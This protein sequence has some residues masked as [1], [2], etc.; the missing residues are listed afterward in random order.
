MALTSEQQKMATDAGVQ[1][2][3]VE[4][5]MSKYPGLNPDAAVGSLVGRKKA[6]AAPT[7][8]LTTSPSD[9]YLQR[10]FGENGAPKNPSDASFGRLNGDPL[11]NVGA[12]SSDPYRQMIAD[13]GAAI[14]GGLSGGSASIAA[15][16]SYADKILSDRAA[17]IDQQR[18]DTQ[19]NINRSYEQGKIQLQNKQ[20]QETGSSSAGL[21]RIGGYLGES[22]SGM[23]Y[24]KKLDETHQQELNTLESQRQAALLAAD[25]AFSSQQ[26][27]VAMQQVANAKDAEQK[28]FERKNALIDNL[29]KLQQIKKFER[30]NAS[31]T[32]DAL[33]KAGIPASALPQGYLES[34]DS[35]M[36]YP[37][38]VSSAMFDAGQVAKQQANAKNLM[39]LRTS[40]I[41]QAGKII[42][43]Q[44]KL[45]LGTPVN[46]GG[47][48]YYG[49]DTGDQTT[50][51]EVDDSGMA[52]G[53]VYNKLSD[54]WSISDLGYIGSKK[55][56]FELK[57]DKYGRPWNYNPKTGQFLSA[58]A[59][60]VPYQGTTSA[61][62]WGQLIPTGTVWGAAWGRKNAGQCGAFVNDLTG[63]GMGDSFASK[64]A[65]IDKSIS[66]AAGNVQVGDVAVFKGGTT[67][68][69]AIVEQV[70]QDGPDGQTT[71]RLM[72]ANV[73]GDGK[74]TH[75]RQ[76]TASD[77]SLAGF[78]RGQLDPR[79]TSGPDAPP[80]V[81]IFAGAE[82]DKGT[83]KDVTANGVTTTYL[84]K[85][86]IATPVRI[87]GG[88]STLNSVATTE[89]R[90]L[91]NQILRKNAQGGYDA[92]YTLPADQTA[93]KELREVGGVPYL[94]DKKTG[95]LEQAPITGPDGTVKFLNSG[96]VTDP[97]DPKVK[98]LAA[99]YAAASTETARKS[100]TDQA[101]DL[102]VDPSA[103]VNAAAG[104]QAPAGQI[105]STV[106]HAPADVDEPFRRAI[107]TQSTIAGD[108]LPRI[109]ETLLSP[110][111][112]VR[113]GTFYSVKIK[114]LPKE[115]RTQME[116]KITSLAASLQTEYFFL[117]SGAQVTPQ[118]EERLN[119]AIPSIDATVA[120]NLD[121]IKS[122][123][124]TMYDV[125]AR[126]LRSRGLT[127]SGE[128]I[129]VR[130]K[131]SG[132]V[133]KIPVSEFKSSTYEVLQ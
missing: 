118:E 11:T 37:T 85:N 125:V 120:E 66:L 49:L 72:E 19:E 3:D 27:D 81:P 4:A 93:T 79:L 71:I 10:Y 26:F 58:A 111:D 132:Q 2:A 105:V 7:L 113:T 77:P 74:V 43:I 62:D 78:A 89:D 54:S 83:L 128:E 104:I 116:D 109:R 45:P 119:K 32:V 67:G 48:T 17:A 82:E 9:P 114:F 53:V 39:E 52:R 86:G 51:V 35:A 100:I 64:A 16:G 44:K 91:G 130:E 63:V 34:L 14:T 22:A 124:T 12:Y 36:G 101:K 65:K 69:V 40:V 110:G 68:H 76:V 133:G 60:G 96:G 29:F 131:S 47:L 8:S 75:G 70:L 6:P 1:P 98:D 61:S 115:F 102:G 18:K 107:S 42:D 126:D 87:G 56:G 5:E 57:I 21:A 90:V 20:E 88:T 30:D 23:A 95:K 13:T 117:K 41:D 103:V 84:V 50:Q 38:G 33:V 99:R 127:V 106:S 122:F 112:K 97:N 73:H 92:I 55:D 28:I 59:P 80:N 24:M 108:I 31:D 121:R 46:V 123:K 94:F 129:V 25:S 15:T